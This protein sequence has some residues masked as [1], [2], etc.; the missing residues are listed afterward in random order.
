MSASNSKGKT[1]DANWPLPS[2]HFSVKIGK[3][4]WRFQEVGNLTA[5]I[6]VLTYRHGKS[7]HEGV[8]KV[9]GYKKVEDVVLKKGIFT[10]NTKLFA[11]FKTTTTKDIE[12][13]DVVISLLN[14]KGEVEIVWN[15]S[16][17]FPSKIEGGNF[18]SKATGES[19]AS[20]ETLTLSFE[21]L[22]I[23]KAK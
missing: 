12:R 17:A 9:P 6:E 13:K 4:T 21:E 7:G 2:F 1:Q 18:N 5:S 22:E 11:W 16:K 19:A 23:E 10:G 20:I 14:E 8:Y 3:E 15:L